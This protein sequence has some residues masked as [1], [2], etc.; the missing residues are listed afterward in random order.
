LTFFNGWAKFLPRK[1][2][3]FGATPIINNDRSLMDDS[4]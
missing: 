1:R 2:F 3:L 4:S